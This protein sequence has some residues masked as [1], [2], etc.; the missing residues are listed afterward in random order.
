MERVGSVAKLATVSEVA[1]I[2]RVDQSTVRGWIE[3]GVIPYVELPAK[4]GQ[5][6]KS[7]RIPL[8]AL[9]QSLVKNF[10]LQPELA[11]AE[12]VTNVA[13]SRDADF[14]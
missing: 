2:L 3:S 6:R 9:L 13:E 14:E 8:Q 7:H 10:D 5:E 1:E 12:S 4:P 11:D